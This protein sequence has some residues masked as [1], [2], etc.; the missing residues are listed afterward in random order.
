MKTSPIAIF[1]EKRPV[2]IS[3]PCSAE[4]EE[5]VLE[6]CT[7]IAKSGKVDILRA[8]IWKP[9][10]RPNSFEGVG[11]EG[12]QWLKKAKE[13]TGLPTA[14]E[15][16][17]FNHVFEALKHGVDILWVGAR[18][19]VNPFS[20]Q[21]IADALKGTDATVMIKNPVHADIE[22]WTGALERLHGAGITKLGLIHRG[23]A[24]YGNSV[25]R[26]DPKWQLAIEMKRRFPEI[27]MVCDP[28]HICGKRDLLHAVSQQALD[29]DFDGLMLESHIDPSNALSDKDQQLT[30]KDLEIIIDNLVVRRP[31]IS[32]ED[33]SQKLS[34]LRSQIDLI[35][36]DLIKLLGERMKVAEEIG[37]VKREKGITIL[38]TN[39]WEEI[40]EKASETGKLQ[41]LSKNFMIR[42]LNAIH[43]ESIEHQNE[44]MNRTEL[45]KE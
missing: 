31:N 33:L 12:L 35:D 10:T 24:Q 43:Q 14:V 29:M 40:I 15:V 5:Q 27:P 36:D 37:L 4:T 19:T 23:F 1:K 21:E 7:T 11:V 39:R 3:G 9:R 28:S 41:G 44:V 42:Y 34:M 17:N 38:Q 6:T 18:T 26:N 16:A 30:P 8:G 20:V 45:E 32:D 2:I 25:Y 22:L 13:A